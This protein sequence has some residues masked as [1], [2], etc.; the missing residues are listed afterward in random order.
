[1]VSWVLSPPPLLYAF[2]LTP[3]ADPHE[4]LRGRYR[5]LR[6]EC[7]ERSERR[8]HERPRLAGGIDGIDQVFARRCLQHVPEADAERLARQRAIVVDGYEN[9][10]YR[11]LLQQKLLR[12]LDS[13]QPGHADVGDD[14]IGLEPHRRFDQRFAVAYDREHIEAGA[15]KPTQLLSNVR[16]VFRKHDCGTWHRVSMCV[17]RCD[18]YRN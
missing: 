18:Y 7:F 17:V 14:D 9:D 16:M 4:D 3:T 2:S 12:G 10:A 5:R 13:V 6:D 15:E 1:M 11:R 8:R